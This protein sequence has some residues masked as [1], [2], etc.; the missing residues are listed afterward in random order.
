MADTFR[1]LDAAVQ[2]HIA[3]VF[4]GHLTD[5][6]I[7][8]THSNSLED[9]GL[10]NY[11]MVFGDH[12]GWHVDAGLVSAAGRIVKDAWDYDGADEDD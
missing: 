7:L 10:H 4:P 8:V 5:S 11:R 9:N 1:T 6:W 2:A 12:Q 3:E